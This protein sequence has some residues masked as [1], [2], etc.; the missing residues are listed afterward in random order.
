VCT[1]P[2]SIYLLSFY[3][4]IYLPSSQIGKGIG[5]PVVSHSAAHSEPAILNPGLNELGEK[6]Y[7]KRGLGELE[8]V[9]F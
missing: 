5:T 4:L 6:L 1:L 3:F 9:E 2:N 8:L 7:K